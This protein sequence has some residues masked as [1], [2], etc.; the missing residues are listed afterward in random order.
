MKIFSS[1]H[2]AISVFLVII[3]VPTLIVTSLF[4]DTSR[5]FLAKSVTE[6]A[7]DLA[8]NSELSQFDGE[9]EEMYGL[10]ATAQSEDD[11]MN[12]LDKYFESCLISAGVE[13]TDVSKYGSVLSDL[14]TDEND[15]YSDL[16]MIDTVGDASITAVSDG[17]LGNSEILK[18]QIVS[19]MKYRA[20][21]DIAE[22]ILKKITDASDKTEIIDDEAEVTEAMQNYYEGEGDVQEQLYNCYQDLK[23]YNDKGINSS[24]V[25]DLSDLMSGVKDRYKTYHIKMFKDLYN[26]ENIGAF[27]TAEGISSFSNYYKSF[28]T[29]KLA[30]AQS[31]IKSYISTAEKAV[32]NFGTYQSKLENECK[33]VSSSGSGESTSYSK[34]DSDYALQLYVKIY[35]D[36]GK[37][38]F[39]KYANAAN[40]MMQLVARM[41][42]AKE[43]IDEDDS[44]YMSSKKY[45][46]SPQKTYSD[47]FDEVLAEYNA[48]AVNDKNA[49]NLT[50]DTRN[51]LY[52]V[53]TY[54]AGFKSLVTGTLYNEFKSKVNST[55]ING[56]VSGVASSLSEYRNNLKEAKACIDDAIKDLNKA[57]NKFKSVPGLYATWGETINSS[58]FNGK[59][60]SVVKESKELRENDDATKRF[61]EDVTADNL[62]ELNTRL[63]N[64]SDLLQNIIDCIDNMKYF[65]TKV[66]SITDYSKFKSAAKIDSSQIVVNENTLSS[67]AENSFSFTAPNLDE[68]KITNNNN[69]NLDNAPIPTVYDYMK[70]QL[71]G[72]NEEDNGSKKNY[73]KIKENNNGTTSLDDDESGGSYKD[74]IS[75]NEIG[76][77]GNET[78][79][80]S[81]KISKITE[82]V[83]GLFDGLSEYISDPSK[84][85]DDY[86]VLDYC[87]NNFSYHTYNKEGLYNLALADEQ[88]GLN[89]ISTVQSLRSNSDY[90]ELWQ[91]EDPVKITDNKS[92]T[93]YMINA[94]NNYSFG[95][96][97]EYILYGGSNASNKSKLN[98]KLFMIRYVLDLGVEF[99]EN[100][101]SDELEIFA[102]AVHSACPFIPAALVKVVVILGLTAGEAA[103]DLTCL[104]E[105][106]KVPLV[107]DK[108]DLVCTLSSEAI[109]SSVATTA[110]SASE[111]NGWQYSDYLSVFLFLDLTNTSKESDTIN[112]IGD[113]IARNVG[114]KKSGYDNESTIFD[115]SKANTYYRLTADVQVKPLLLSL[116]LT[117][118]L[119]MNTSEDTTWFTWKYSVTRGYN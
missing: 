66:T 46:T 69:P 83:S 108:D 56:Y 61:Q 79:S 22:N 100:W 78:T 63:S 117:Q 109:T 89:V 53:N 82:Q 118:S 59:D 64:I 73:K 103:Y 42:K 16:L 55:E 21:V 77:G 3:L 113:V 81:N 119:S 58:A 49:S 116:P 10:F 115:M 17:N 80:V 86:Y 99:S 93:N 94:E 43:L 65:N 13:T 6:S 33:L 104:K 88:N 95:N 91:N 71:G 74:V 12:N 29:M 14:L 106:M 50:Y 72:N 11:V 1:N 60:S 75:T 62:D 15:E 48:Y 20:P 34:K 70:N 41:C 87:M 9:L 26:T 19:F 39:A 4:V 110:K 38:F 51:S 52:V 96:E 28:S 111:I 24:Y 23:K 36:L 67:N 5:M 44:T 30:K 54:Y 57:I 2:G 7:A 32:E 25:S 37:D 114:M 85:R 8:L 92:L 68:I 112:R 84:A 40:T 107:K 101:S 31:N 76:S 45:S 105:G 27:S 47:K 35:N 18:N 90:L 98:A 97:I 102:A